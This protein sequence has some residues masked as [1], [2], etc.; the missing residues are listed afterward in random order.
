MITII[1]KMCDGIINDLITFK[2]DIKI[3]Y[4]RYITSFSVIMY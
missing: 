3:I 4:T 2:I 1:L